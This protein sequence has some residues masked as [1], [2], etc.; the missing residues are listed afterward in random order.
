MITIT[1]WAYAL[2]LIAVFGTGFFFGVVSP[3]YRRAGTS[4]LFVTFADG[5]SMTIDGDV[6]QTSNVFYVLAAVVKEEAR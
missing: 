5:A 1:T 3:L 4:R 6:H 2:G